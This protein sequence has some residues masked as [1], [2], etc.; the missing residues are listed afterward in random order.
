MIH[1][2]QTARYLRERK[3][4]SQKVAAEALGIS[5]VHLCNIE[6]NKS[7]P[8]TGLLQ[9]YQTLWGVD[10]YILAWCLH[11]N[12]GDLPENIRRPMAELAKAWRKEL[13]DLVDVKKQ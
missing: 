11:G 7:I 5:S 10:L 3:G 2:G 13:G 6:N 4:L 12:I 9:R 1:V 8:S